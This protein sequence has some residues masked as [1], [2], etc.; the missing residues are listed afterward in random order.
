M[1]FFEFAVLVFECAS[2]GKKSVMLIEKLEANRIRLNLARLDLESL[3]SRFGFSWRDCDD[4]LTGLLERHMD[5]FE[6]LA[7]PWLMASFPGAG[8][9][10][11]ES[12]F[13]SGVAT[14]LDS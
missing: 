5:V 8:F 2:V 4:L 12:P 3:G 11:T 13:K 10:V 1:M 6:R 14:R 7:T 9:A